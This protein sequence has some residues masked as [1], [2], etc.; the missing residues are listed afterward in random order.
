MSKSKK[1]SRR[2]F[3]S[4]AAMSFGAAAKKMFRLMNFVAEFF[5]VSV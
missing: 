2:G 3:L 5:S 4:T 1:Y